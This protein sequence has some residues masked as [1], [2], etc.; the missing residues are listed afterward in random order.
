MADL[1][2]SLAWWARAFGGNR[3]D[4]LD[5]ATPDGTLFACLVSIPG[6]NVPLELRH[7]PQA[8]QRAAGPDPVTFGVTTKQDLHTWADHLESTGIEHSGVLTG[9]DG[10][11]LAI[12]TPDRLTIRLITRESHGWDPAHADLDSPWLSTP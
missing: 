5:H 12:H 11:L 8:A 3:I 9:Y 6:I 7:D 1:D 4:A 10:W 2:V